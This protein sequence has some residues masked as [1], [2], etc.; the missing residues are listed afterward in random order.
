MFWKQINVKSALHLLW[1]LKIKMIFSKNKIKS[2]FCSKQNF[3][4]IILKLKYWTFSFWV[5]VKEANIGG[6]VKVADA[7]LAQG[8]V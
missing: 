7:M 4:K 1:L 8:L 3:T 6:F 5:Y 2:D